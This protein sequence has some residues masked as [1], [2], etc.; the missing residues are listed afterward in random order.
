MDDLA[1]V[2]CGGAGI[3]RERR[4]WDLS[5]V[6]ELVFGGR[7]ASPRIRRQ[8]RRWKLLADTEVGFVRCRQAGNRWQALSRDSSVGSV[9]GF[10]GGFRAGYCWQAWR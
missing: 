1:I 2:R 4:S 5:A 8:V 3:C 7:G 6:V 9:I 10:I